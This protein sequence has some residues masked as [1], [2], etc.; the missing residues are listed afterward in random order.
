MKNEENIEFIDGESR[1][2]ER[3]KSSPMTIRTRRQSQNQMIE[4]H[5]NSTILSIFKGNIQN[6]LAR[7]LIK[8]FETPHYTLKLFLL[9]FAVITSA[10]NFYMIHS[11]IITYL[12]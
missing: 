9:A 5:K 7:S 1:E 2:C 6:S 11:S 10:L 4:N 12:R 8:I 3:R